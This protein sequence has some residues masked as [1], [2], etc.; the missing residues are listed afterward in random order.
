MF[1]TVLITK[2]SIQDI[3]NVA[4][5]E[6]KDVNSFVVRGLMADEGDGGSVADGVEVPGRKRV[7]WM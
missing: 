3:T 5:S 7:D 1:V 2:H 4:T 6:K